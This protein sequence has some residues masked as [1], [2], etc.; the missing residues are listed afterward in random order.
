MMFLK[1]NCGLFIYSGLPNSLKL[2]ILNWCCETFTTT[3]PL[4]N[5]LLAELVANDKPITLPAFL[6][7]VAETLPRVSEL[8]KDLL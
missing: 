5:D 1:Y 3:E 8:T 4:S 2:S 7:L 6:T